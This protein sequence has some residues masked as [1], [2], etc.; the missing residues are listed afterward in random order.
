LL[1]I[2]CKSRSKSIPNTICIISLQK[3]SSKP[4]KYGHVGDNKTLIPILISG[5]F[6]GLAIFARKIT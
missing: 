2:S 4:G 5:I 6:L 3:D 1:A